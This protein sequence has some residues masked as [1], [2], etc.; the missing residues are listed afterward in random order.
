MHGGKIKEKFRNARPSNPASE[1]LR[2]FRAVGTLDFHRGTCRLLRRN[3]FQVLLNVADYP[4]ALRRCRAYRPEVSNSVETPRWLRRWL[5][6]QIQN[7]FW[8][9]IKSN[10]KYFF[11]FFLPFFCLNYFSWLGIRKSQI[12]EFR[13]LIVVISDATPKLRNIVK[14]QQIVDRFRGSRFII[15]SLITF[16]PQCNKAGTL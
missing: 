16:S 9:Y 10:T 6:S 12:I 11:K 2:G 5:K 1:V 3:A 4:E 8:K 15:I 14:S 7:Y 13:C